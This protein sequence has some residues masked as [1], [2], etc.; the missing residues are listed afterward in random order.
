MGTLGGNLLLDTR[1]NYYDQNYEWRQAI[2]FCMKKDGAICWVAPGSPK[3]LAVQSA[4]SVPVLIAL[5]ARAVLAVAGRGAGGRGRGPLSQRRHP[6]PHQAA[7]RAP[8]GDPDVPAP[9]A[10]R[11]RTGSCAAG[12]PSIS[13]SS[14]SAPR[15]A[16]KT[17]SSRRRASSWAPFPPRPCGPRRPRR[18]WSGVRL[19]ATAIAEAA[20]ARGGPFPTDGQHRLLVPLAQGDDEEVG[21]GG[22]RAAPGGGG[23]AAGRPNPDAGP[24]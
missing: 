4:D 16:A 11:R 8:D 17:A 19:D 14:R 2:D 18:I 12:A 23:R 7:G 1:C 5:G 13:R 6:L 3:C 20:A 9:P 15:C 22:P 21:R 10:G 24:A